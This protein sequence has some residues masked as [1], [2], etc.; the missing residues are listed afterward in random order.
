[1]KHD[2]RSCT[3]NICKERRWL[4]ETSVYF[5]GYDGEHYLP[6]PF[7]NTYNGEIRIYYLAYNVCYMP[8][9]INASNFIKPDAYFYGCSEDGIRILPKRCGKCRNCRYF[10]RRRFIARSLR[11]F[12]IYNNQSSQMAP[13]QLWTLGTSLS[14][15]RDN[16]VTLKR[17]WRLFTQRINTY[18]K[19]GLIS[20]SP[21][22]RVFEAGTIGKRLHVHFINVGTIKHSCEYWDSDSTGKY[23]NEEFKCT[24]QCV[25]CIWRSITQE[26]SNVNFRSKRSESP[27]SAFSYCAKY[28][29]KGNRY[30]YLGNFRLIKV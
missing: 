7:L 6:Y 25:T 10:K 9:R 12:E 18:K 5:S 16:Y 2:Y 23:L 22:V 11:K 20:Y 29:A 19:R 28:I 21:I 14:D 13:I 4:K 26:K 3:C 17:Y 27:M 24:T 15:T 30:S 1:M 8:Y